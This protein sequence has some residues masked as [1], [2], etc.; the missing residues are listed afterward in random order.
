MYVISVCGVVLF[1]TDNF[2]EFITQFKKYQHRFGIDGV[3]CSCNKD[4]VPTKSDINININ[5]RVSY[6]K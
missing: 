6:D 4:V 1:S 5:L 3:E 2:L